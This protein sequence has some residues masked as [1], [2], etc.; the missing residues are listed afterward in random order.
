M[1]GAPLSSAFVAAAVAPIGI[2]APTRSFMAPAP[3]PITALAFD[4][5]QELLV[6]RESERANERARV[7]VVPS[8][9]PACAPDPDPRSS[10]AH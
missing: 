4:P 1:F 7:P 9:R 2:T 6:K 10:T 5:V 3:V 8:A